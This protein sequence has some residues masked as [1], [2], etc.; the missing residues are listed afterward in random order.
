M[1]ASFL[2]GSETVEVN[3]GARTIAVVKAGVIGLVGI[4]PK[5]PLNTLT[6]VNDDTAAAQ[7][8]AELPGFSIPQA[9]KSIFAQGAGTILVVNVFDATTMTSQVTDE[10]HAMSGGKFKTTYAPVSNFVLKS[11]DGN[12]T[13]VKDT[14]YTLDDYGNVVSL[15]IAD[16]TL[17][18]SYKKLNSAAVT[19]TEINGEID[20]DTGAL[21]GMKVFNLAYNLFGFNPKL[22]IAPEF[23][24]LSA[25][26][27][28]M[29]S[30]ANKF[31]G[32]AIIDAP[33][34]T[35]VA[36]AI[37]GRGPA[38][39]INFNTSSKRAALLYPMLKA[40]DPYSVADEVRPY[41]SFFAGV[42]AAVINNEGFHVS[43]SNHEILGITGVE[44]NI[45]ASVDDATADTNTLN[46]AGII[47]YFSSFGTGY[48]VWGNRSAAYPSSTLTR[49]VFLACQMTASVLDESIR[50]AMLQFIDK[51]VDQAWIDSVRESVNGFIRTLVGRGAL[52][53]G[54]CIFDPAKNTA[55]EMAAGHYTFS[56]SF[57]SPV[58]G[59]RL[60]FESTYD[61]NLLKNLK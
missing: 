6:L 17:K 14:D 30:V 8:G 33:E 5:G 42:W 25:V 10:S 44:R 24:S 1:T 32:F 54:N 18:A 50:Y 56:Y 7:F 3:V 46:A 61:I 15:T 45:S 47:T 26:A 27:T 4:A 28:E 29:I 53:D 13:Y 2:H 31:K 23:S 9:I 52:I 16:A 58:P 60:T 59:E 37:A 11:N 43:P 41:S 35:T 36:N 55:E 21:S 19:A 48:R 20:G 34:S 12:T 22:I 57:A 49:D 38:G 40:Y 51:P 39:A